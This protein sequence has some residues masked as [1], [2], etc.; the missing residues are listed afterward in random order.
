MYL[1]K[2]FNAHEFVD[3]LIIGERGNKSFELIDDRILITA[4]QLRKAFGKTT[5]NNWNWGGDRKWSGL[6]SK[7]SPYY[8]PTSQHTFG[9]AID[10]IFEDVTAEEA[11]QYILLHPDQFPHVSFI[12]D[13]VSWLHVDCRN[14]ERISVWSPSNNTIRRC[15]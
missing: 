13:E 5:I 15:E 7:S 14:C 10:C 2:Y 1:P 3:P 12:E 11:R 4:D 8:S 6:R 9:R